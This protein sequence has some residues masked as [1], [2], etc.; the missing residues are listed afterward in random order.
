MSVRRWM[1]LAL[2]AGVAIF[3]GACDAPDASEGATGING[4]GAFDETVS[5]PTEERLEDREWPPPRHVP[6][7]VQDLDESPEEYL[8]IEG[9]R[10]DEELPPTQDVED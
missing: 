6:G 1:S 8:G 7:A 3:V 9:D 2:S 5:E 10:Y 4:A